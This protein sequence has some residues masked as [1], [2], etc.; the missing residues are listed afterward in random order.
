MGSIAYMRQVYLDAEHYRIANQFYAAHSRG[1]QRPDYDRALEGVLDSPRVL[2]P[3]T[4]RMDVD[5]ML[6]FAEE[7]H[8]KPYCTD[9]RKATGRPTC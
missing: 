4:R 3:A 5:R 8:C 7:L 1:T 6:R 2:L 9:F